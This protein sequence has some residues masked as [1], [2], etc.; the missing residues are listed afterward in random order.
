MW[1]KKTQSSINGR[2]YYLFR[3]LS[4]RPGGKFCLRHNHTNNT[5][6]L[7]Q[8]QKGDWSLLNIS[9]STHYYC[10]FWGALDVIKSSEL[11]EIIHFLVCLLVGYNL[12]PFADTSKQ[13]FTY[14]CSI[15]CFPP[16][17][18]FGLVLL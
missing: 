18:P 8:S 7:C 4:A 1:R 2:Q 6:T 9:Q 14:L 10:E 16:H 3:P 5:Q 15:N 12:L 13:M 11:R 17:P